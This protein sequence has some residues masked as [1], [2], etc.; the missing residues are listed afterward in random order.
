MTMNARVVAVIPSAGGGSR[1]GS[2]VEKQ[3]LPLA[4]K[5]LLAHTLEPFQRSPLV[6]EILLVVPRDWLDK[7][8]DVV[9]KPFALAKV[10]SVVPGG[11]Q[12]QESVRLGLEALKPVWNV[13]LIHDGV[14]PFVTEDLIARSIEETLVHGATLVG[15]PAVDTIKDVD[16]TGRVQ[17]TLQRDRLWMVQTPQAFR[18][19]LIVRAHREAEKAGIV[20]TDDASLVERLGH[21]VRAIPGSYDN[22]K[23][24]TPRDLVFAEAIL[25]HRAK[26]E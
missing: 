25:R 12:R 15:V 3:F 17:T 18:F 23:V 11:A 6:Q 1:F 4:D 20:G 21:E 16:A 19:E 2:P 14:R 5:P 26:Q 7:I 8:M 22:I 10:R 13:V 9:V 24:T